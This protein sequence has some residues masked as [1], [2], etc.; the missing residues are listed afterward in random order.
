MHQKL[1][2]DGIRTRILE[3]GRG[4]PVILVHGLGGSIE[5]WTYNIGPL[6]KHR[7]VVALD[8]PGFGQSDKP[9]MSYSVEFYRNFL[10]KLMQ[11]LNIAR[12]SILGSSLGGQI[13]AEVAIG[14]PDLVDRLVLVS[15]AG[16]LPRSFKAS[17]A[18]KRY[19]RV[20]TARSVQEVK[21]AL[22]AV[23]NKPVK[24]SYAKM[25]FETI[26]APNAREAFLSALK[27]S[28]AAPRLDRRLVRIRSPTLLLWG[29]QDIM[30]P[31]KFVDP[32]VQMKNCR[33]VMLEHCGHR[34]H[35]ERPEVF[36]EIVSGFLKERN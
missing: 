19:L 30:I 9:A 16:A 27:Q 31:A 34:P 8:L 35:V 3:R 29:K 36:N 22:H 2:I 4:K 24:S 13:G 12:A 21:Q 17:P 1:V 5:S 7:R 6:S 25:V 26:S 23:D 28:G 14:R 20:T 15:P 10:G 18:L 32:F 33:V 11:H